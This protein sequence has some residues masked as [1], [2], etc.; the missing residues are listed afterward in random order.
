M[1]VLV[2]VKKVSDCWF[3]VALNGQNELVASTISR[4]GKDDIE[5]SFGPYLRRYDRVEREADPRAGRLIEALYHMYQGKP[6]SID[7]RL[8]MK[9]IA[10]F[11]QV[12]YEK[13]RSIP[14]GRVATYGAIARSLG[15]RASRAVGH[16]MAM[17]PFVLVVPCHRVVRS[18]LEIGNYG[19]GPEVKRQ[20]L[21]REGVFFAGQKVS[22][23]SVWTPP[24]RQHNRK[25][26]VETYP[27][28]EGARYG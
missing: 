4:K 23:L 14:I 9:H 5:V 27:R 2:S 16:A 19:R 15:S 11:H 12:V 21:R 1:S 25:Y 24:A 7:T 20:L 28:I 3:G 13:A 8:N 6:T 17:N 10:P 26:V 18:T 22:P